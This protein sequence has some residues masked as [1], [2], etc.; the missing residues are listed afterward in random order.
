MG[1]SVV[2]PHRIEFHCCILGQWHHCHEGA[3]IQYPKTPFLSF[4]VLFP[5][6]LVSKEGL[7]NH[8]ISHQQDQPII[9]SLEG[10]HH[11]NRGT[12]VE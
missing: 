4:Q 12:Y 3:N 8:S 2:M 7:R 6:S 5:F 10:S 11:P 1:K 9:S